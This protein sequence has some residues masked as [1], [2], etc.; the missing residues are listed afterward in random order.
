MPFTASH[1]AAVIPLARWGLPSSALVI[2]SVAPD[3]PAMLQIPAL[4]HFA[5]TPLGVLSV[6]L[7]VAV[8]GFVLWQALFGPA[9]AAVAP[10]AL[11]ARLP[12]RVLAG[13]KYHFGCYDRAARAVAAALLG[14]VTHFLWDGFTHNWMWG[15][16]LF[17]WLVSRHGP[18]LGWQ[19]MQHISNAAGLAIVA[20][21]VTAWW[22]AAPVHPD[23]AVIPLPYRALAWLAILCPAT[24]GFCYWLL[25][26]SFYVAITRAA[27]LGFIG[28][29]AVAV[30]RVGAHPTAPPPPTA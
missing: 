3:M 12:R 25:R 10:K 24:V 30:W 5:H 9:V 22:R 17:P 14:V 15:Q 11:C 27:G 19:W 26:D 6:D 2:G 7:I 23:T 8:A 29:T 21:W 20:A 28:L 1:P 16:Q 4:V 18:L 13:A